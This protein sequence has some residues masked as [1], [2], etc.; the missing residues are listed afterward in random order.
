MLTVLT[1]LAMMLSTGTGASAMCGLGGKAGSVADAS[2]AHAGHSAT[3]DVRMV[4]VADAM[5]DA[6]AGY[7][8]CAGDGGC[9]HGVCTPGL[10]VPAGATATRVAVL[11]DD[12]GPMRLTSHAMAHQP[13]PPRNHS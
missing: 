7:D 11:H 5:P 2:A 8:M 6:G 1:V 9:D 12:A 10:A 3:D 13:P 4:M